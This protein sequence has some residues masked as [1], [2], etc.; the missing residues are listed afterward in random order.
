[1]LEKKTI[2]QDALISKLEVDKQDANQV[3]SLVEE[4]GKEVREKSVQV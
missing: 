3:K 1:M 2:E 4:E